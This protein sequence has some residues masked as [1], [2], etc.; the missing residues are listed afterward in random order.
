MTALFR[1]SN[2]AICRFVVREL[3]QLLFVVLFANV[4]ASVSLFEQSCDVNGA[5]Q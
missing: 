4:V 1:F 3:G 5:K 2:I